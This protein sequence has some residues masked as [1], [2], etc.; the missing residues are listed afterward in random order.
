MTVNRRAAAVAMVAMVTRFIRA[1][2]CDCYVYDERPKASTE[3]ELEAKAKEHADKMGRVRQRGT[4]V[5]VAGAGGS[6]DSDDSDDS[7]D[8]TEDKAAAAAAAAD[9]GGSSDG[10]DDF[11][12]GG[13]GDAGDGV[14]QPLAVQDDSDDSDEFA[15]LGSPAK[16]ANEARQPAVI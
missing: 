11:D 15:P 12:G 1:F 10:S 16:N 4:R 2:D 14:G 9:A 13:A 7:D 8:Y 5:K 3:D 6:S